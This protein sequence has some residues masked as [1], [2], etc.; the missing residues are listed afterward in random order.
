LGNSLSEAFTGSLD[1]VGFTI[2]NLVVNRP[3]NEYI[4]LFG[5]LDGAEVRDLALVDINIYGRSYTGTGGL[6][7]YATNSTLADVEVIGMVTG[8]SYTGGLVGH[9]SGGMLEDSRAAVHVVGNQ[10]TGGLAGRAD[11]EAQISQ[12]YSLGVV[13]GTNSYTG[14]LAGYFGDGTIINSYSQASVTGTST[15]GG[16]IGR[17]IGTGSYGAGAYIDRSY[18]TGLV[19]G[20]SNVGGLVG[21]GATVNDSYW[22][23]ETSGQSTSAGG[24]GK[25]TEQMQLQ[26]TFTNWDFPTVWVIEEGESYPFHNE[27]P[28]MLA[29]DS[30]VRFHPNNAV[31]GQIFDVISNLNWT[32]MTSDDWITI[33]GGASGRDNGS[34]IYSVDEN[35]T[36]NQRSGSI[37]VSDGSSITRVFSIHQ[38]GTILEIYPGSRS[39]DAAA[40][41]GHSIQITGN[42]DWTAEASDTW[43]ILTSAVGGTGSGNVTYRL[44]EN[45]ALTVR[46]GNITVSG[47]GITH[48]YTVAQAAAEPYC[49]VDHHYAEYGH[50]ASSGNEITISANQDW[51]AAASDSWINLTNSSG[52]G[53]GT[54][55]YNIDENLNRKSRTGYI[56]ISAG[57]RTINFRVTQALAWFMSVDFEP[58]GSGSVTGTG[59]YGDS[60]VVTLDLAPNPGYTFTNWTEDGV[61]VS[62]SAE[63]SFTSQ[64][65]RSLVANFS[66]SPPM[67]TSEAE[68]SA[69]QDVL[70]SYDVTATDS[71]DGDVLTITAETKPEWLNFTDNGNGTASLTGTP[72]NAE[73]GDHDVVLRVTD[74]T[75]ETDTQ[76]FTITVA[77]V[78]DAPGF[79]STPV[80]EATQDVAYA[81]E[82]TVTDPDLIHGDVL[83]IT[84]ET[85]PEWLN[86]TDNGNGTASLTGTPTNAEVGDHDV[87]LRVTDITSETDT[88]EFTIT[89]E[90]APDQETFLYLPLINR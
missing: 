13:E 40:S 90:K 44:T 49:E 79:T 51:T 74:I 30:T 48:T 19:T 33:T 76:E 56:V 88:Q 65:S 53:N 82:I 81:Y 6:A 12:S 67:F 4:G 84:A 77:N 35:L 60:E 89:V 9:Q 26:A 39:H 83:T 78:N 15:V 24:T 23:I 80:T 38:S 61:E 45:E 52:S 87:V 22:D 18:S 70:Y 14:G 41:S 62:T 47:G 37:T 16:L 68:T 31:D 72:P 34:V 42:V 11:G 58:S 36:T 85:K 64:R 21:S 57:D 69:T 7:G 2:S 86:F 8:N 3:R 75:S 28:R 55:T 50:Q 32:A 10:Y 46:E 25:T 29:L 71:D 27:N 73:V 43:I 54:L 5:Y 20:T 17:L 66:T 59:P 63:Y 1:G